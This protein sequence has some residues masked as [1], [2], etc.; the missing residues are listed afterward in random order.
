MRNKLDRQRN[1]PS[2]EEIAAMCLEIQ[3]SWSPRMKLSRLRSD[4]RPSYMRS[5]GFNEA[6]PVEDYDAHHE[7]R[8]ALQEIATCQ[9]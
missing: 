7:S 9:K 3:K 2:P 6:M 8:E 4:W 5:D 1:D